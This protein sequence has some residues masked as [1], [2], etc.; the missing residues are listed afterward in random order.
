M[1]TT[2]A[3]NSRAGRV[4]AATAAANVWFRVAADLG[5]TPRGAVKLGPRAWIRAIA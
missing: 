3:V 1:A 5:P 2:N 4:P